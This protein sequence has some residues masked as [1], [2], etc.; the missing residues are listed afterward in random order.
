MARITGIGYGRFAWMKDCDGNRNRLELW[1]P[2][3]A[4]TKD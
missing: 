2:L 3:V 4:L 1:Q